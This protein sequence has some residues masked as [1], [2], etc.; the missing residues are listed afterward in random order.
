MSKFPEPNHKLI[1]E[2]QN[3]CKLLT[4]NLATSAAGELSFSFARRLGT[5]HRSRMGDERFSNL[6]VLEWPQAGMGD[7]LLATQQG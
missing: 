7:K 1:R 6:A 3:I 5:W 2:I 4:V